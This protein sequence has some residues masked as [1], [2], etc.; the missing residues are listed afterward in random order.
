MKTAVR[1]GADA[2]Y[3]GGGAYSLRSG[4]ASF[5]LE[6]LAE[7][8]RFAHGKGC[9]VYL[10][11][12][13]FAFDDDL[14]RMLDYY[15]EGE[16]LGIDAVIISEPGV[17]YRLKEVN[18]RSRIHL[19][20]QANTTNSAS[21]MFWKE[22]GVHRINLSRE[23]SLEQVQKIKESVPEMELEIFAHGAMCAAYSGRCFLSKFLSNRSAN[24]GDC[25]Q[26]CRWEYY[27][28]EVSR[29][30]E[31]T[32]AEDERGSYIL[33]SRDM[34]TIKHI[35]DLAAAR[36]DSIKIE[37][38]MKSAYYVAAV[39]RVYRSALNALFMSGDN[40]SF[41]PSWLEELKKVSH[42]PYTTGFYF[43]GKNEETEYTARASYIRD[44]DFVG[45]VENHFVKEN[46]LRINGRNRFV[47]G[48]VLEILDPRHPDFI[49]VKVEKIIDVDTGQ[50]LE[51]AHNGYRVDIPLPEEFD[52][53]L[54]RESIVRCKS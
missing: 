47:P 53:K 52:Q 11:L 22:Q 24:R 37:G 43:P 2:V 29:L 26:P 4:G 14:N 41:E 32:I 30:E 50:K 12:N 17:F 42:R 10:A 46:I 35:P 21:V 1:F 48:D 23:L 16:K 6:D 3:C 15:R 13:I 19:S 51:A 34:C 45:T 33:N 31:M 27:L 8:V 38:R 20:T 49:E 25:S 44:Y 40:Y 9:N 54:S 36:V 18:P 7:G 39:T 5:S 28:R